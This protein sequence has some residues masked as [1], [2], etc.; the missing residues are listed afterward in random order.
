VLYRKYFPFAQC[1]GIQCSVATDEQDQRIAQLEARLAQALKELAEAL[2]ENGAL[3]EVVEQ[4][5]RAIEEW[6]R[7]FRERRKRRTSRAEGKRRGTGKPRGRRVGHD[8]AH[9]AEPERIDQD[10]AT[11]G[12]KP[13]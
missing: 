9:R 3:R 13:M 4:Q 11:R 10:G 8:G 7:G 1:S 2:K 5:K 12:S 6:K